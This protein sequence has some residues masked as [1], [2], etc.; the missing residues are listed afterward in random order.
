MVTSNIDT[1]EV[2][3]S[4]WRDTGAVENCNFGGGNFLSDKF[5][6][7]LKS[8]SESFLKLLSFIINLHK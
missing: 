4:D 2:I 6:K 3:L 7:P 5:F 8:H 1:I